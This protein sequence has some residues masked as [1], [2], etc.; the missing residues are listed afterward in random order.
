VALADEVQAAVAVAKDQ[1]AAVRLDVAVVRMQATRRIVALDK[2]TKARAARLVVARRK[3]CFSCLSLFVV[4]DFCI[5]MLLFSCYY[6]LFVF[7]STLF[8]FRFQ[9]CFPVRFPSHSLVTAEDLD[10]ELT[11]YM[12]KDEK[13]GSALLDQDLDEYMAKRDAEV[14]KTD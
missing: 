2:V 13:I 6:F 12:L 1:H 4:L 11:K 7:R 8:V 3:V 9:F 5:R 14:E 10:K